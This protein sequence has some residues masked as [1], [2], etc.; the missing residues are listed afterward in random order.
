MLSFIKKNTNLKHLKSYFYKKK[1]KKIKNHKIIL[2]YLKSKNCEHRK[3]AN[4]SKIYINFSTKWYFSKKHNLKLPIKWKKLDTMNL[5]E[6]T[7][8]LFL[9]NKI[10]EDDITWFY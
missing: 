2:K 10:N 8:F 7:Q 6:D 9:Q 5:F 4:L 3:N 1:V